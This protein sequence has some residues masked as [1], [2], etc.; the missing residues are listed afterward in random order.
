M[1]K[2]LFVSF[3]I[4]MVCAAFVVFAQ[5]KQP[6]ERCVADTECEF[7]SYCKDGVCTKKKEFDFGDSS[8]TGKPCQIDADC[9]GS[10]KC[11][12]GDFGKKHCSGG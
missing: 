1:K 9:I 8:K 3:V 7:N 4:P 2:F 10:G 11:V 12:E 5:S 6:G